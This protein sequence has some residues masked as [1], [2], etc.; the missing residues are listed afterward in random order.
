MDTI[1][2]WAGSSP[3]VIRSVDEIYS[4]N[5]AKNP[6]LRLCIAVA[7]FPHEDAAGW[8]VMVRRIY[9]IH[10]EDGELQIDPLSTYVLNIPSSINP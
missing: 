4:L 6:D 3:Y 8:Q 10:R 1:K 7:T 2:N 5:L 9:E